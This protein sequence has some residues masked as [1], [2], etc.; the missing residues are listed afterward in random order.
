Y[1]PLDPL[2]REIRLLKVLQRKVLEPLGRP[3][4]CEL[5]HASF[6]AQLVYTAF[7]Y[8]WGN[9]NIHYLIIVNGNSLHVTENLFFALRSI[10]RHHSIRYL[11]VDAVCI[12]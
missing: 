2:A 9:P 6:E 7:S 3:V 10:C 4:F 8:I 11:W 1:H 5:V 12:N